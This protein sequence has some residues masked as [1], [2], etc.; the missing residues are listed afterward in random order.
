MKVKI[1]KSNLK[2]TIE[3]PPSK[4]Y[5][6]RVIIAAS[7][8]DGISILKNVVKSEDI[9]ATIQAMR[10]LGVDITEL[11]NNKLLI[12]G[13]GQLK[14]IRNIINCNQSGSTLRFIIP[15]F[16]FIDEELI[17]TGEKNLINRPLNTY[18][19]LF[20]DKG[21]KYSTDDGKL[22]LTVEGELEPGDYYIEGDIS[23]QFL[24][25]LMFTLPLLN[26]NSRI[27]LTTELKSKSYID[28][29]LDIL[30]IFGVK[31]LNTDYKKFYIPGFQQYKPTDYSIESD[32]SQAAFWIVAN[33]LGG[34]IKLHG[35]DEQTLQGDVQLLD[36]VESMGAKI[37]FR[38]KNLVITKANELQSFDIDAS[39]IPDLVPILTVLGCFTTGQSRIY[40]AERLKYKESNRL[41]AITK[42]LNKLGGKVAM[43]DGGLVINPIEEF[44]GGEVNSWNDHRIA[45]ALAIASLKAKGDVIINHADAINKSYPKFYKD[46]KKI[47]GELD[48]VDIR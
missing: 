13:T 4:S 5:T 36:I 47:G 40:N 32:Y 42:E 14:V 11:S 45:M 34:D 7:L 21:I 9:L 20:E 39:N 10:K 8:A 31:V 48:V 2:G 16:T 24:T 43:V 29:T 3:I 15:F 12:R 18:Y 46:F 33:L 1:K 38:S 41:E 22:P 30:E 35:L 44:K 19:K 17:F 23:S 37:S 6:H 25:G 28:M 27:I 26:G